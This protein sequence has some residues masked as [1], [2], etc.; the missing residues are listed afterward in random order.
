[1]LLIHGGAGQAYSQWIEEW[2][3]RGYAAIALDLYGDMP[4]EDGTY[5]FNFMDPEEKHMYRSTPTGMCGNGFDL[6]TRGIALP[7]RE[8]SMSSPPIFWR[9][10]CFVP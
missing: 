4:L 8:C 6:R 3:R 1:M 7:I 2:M 9:A 10:T 5:V